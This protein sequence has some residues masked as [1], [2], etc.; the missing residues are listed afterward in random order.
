MP[1]SYILS[2]KKIARDTIITN[3]MININEYINILKTDI[4]TLLNKSID[5]EAMIESFLDQIKYRYTDT[6]SQINIL[7]KQKSELQ[8]ALDTSNTNIEK[9]K[10]D[11]TK[12]YQT[13]NY[14]K[15]Q[16]SLDAYLIEKEKNI[17]ANTYLVFV[18]KFILSY[19]TLNNF[20]KIFLDTI[21]NNK[22]ALIKNVTV[23][24]PDS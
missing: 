20:N 7:T 1:V 13:L 16:E 11:L 3:N 18:N 24:L 2:N 10:Q 6:L 8:K 17:F 19:T 23:V 14:D 21:I 12:A 5:R 9:L 22:D 15:T 4:N